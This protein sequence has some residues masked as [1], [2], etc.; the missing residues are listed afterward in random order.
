MTLGG[1]PPPKPSFFDV[2]YAIPSVA[3]TTGNATITTTGADYWGYAIKM[4]SSPATLIVYNSTTALGVVLDAV[5]VTA[6]TRVM[7]QNPTRARVGISCNFTGT[8]GTVTI[9]YTPKG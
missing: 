1:G 5:T 8:N 9:F 3:V 2:P 4:A 6:S 7:Y